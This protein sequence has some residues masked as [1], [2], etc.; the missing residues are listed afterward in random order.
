MGGYE[1]KNH[2]HTFFN[3]IFALFDG[4]MG[5][6]LAAGFSYVIIY[7]PYVRYKILV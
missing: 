5:N 6:L 7:R 2:I 4:K 1:K 3:T